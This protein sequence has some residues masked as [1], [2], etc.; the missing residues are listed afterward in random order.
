MFAHWMTHHFQPRQKPG[1]AA[2]SGAEGLQRATYEFCFLKFIF[3]NIVFSLYQS[4]FS[5]NA[6]TVPIAAPYDEV[7]A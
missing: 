1:N 6:V 2:L 5:S 7:P 3:Y 4:H